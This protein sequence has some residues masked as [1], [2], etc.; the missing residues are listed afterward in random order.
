MALPPARLAPDAVHM[1][2][3]LPG[4]GAAR[5]IWGGAARHIWG[6]WR[7]LKFL[8]GAAQFFQ[9]FLTFLRLALEVVMRHFWVVV[10]AGL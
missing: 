9:I 10:Y 1:H 2:L 4:P 5:H 7:N 8:V 6:G 3:Y